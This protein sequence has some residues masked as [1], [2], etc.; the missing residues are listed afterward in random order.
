MNLRPALRVFFRDLSATGAVSDGLRCRGQDREQDLSQ[1]LEAVLNGR[2]PTS[3]WN[4]QSRHSQRRRHRLGLLT[5][6]YQFRLVYAGLDFESWCEWETDRWFDDGEGTEELG[7]LRQL[8]SPEALKPVR[9]GVSGLLDAV[10]ESR[11]RQADLSSVL[12]ENVRQAVEYLLEDVSAANRTDSNLFNSLVHH[13][14][15]PTLTDAQAQEALLQATVRVVMRLVVCLFAESRQLLPVND[16]IYAQAYGVRS[17]YESLEEAVRME[18]GVHTLFNHHIAWARLMA[19][20]R[21]IDEGSANGAFPLRADGGILFRR[22]KPDDPDPV[23]RALHLLEHAVPVGDA[24]MHAVLRKLMRGPLP[25][26]RG[27]QKTFV[28]GPVDYTDLRTEFIGLI[29][30][31]L[32]DYRVKRTD[33]EI[34]PQVFLHLGREPVLPLNRLEEMLANDRNGLKNLLTMLRKEA[35]TAK[36]AS[37]EEAEEEATDEPGDAP[38]DSPEDGDAEVEV[39][40]TAEEF[41]RGGEYLDAVASANRWA[42]AAVVLARL[43]SRQKARES[44]GEYRTRIEAEAKR[45]IKRVVATG[46][47][48]LVRAGNTRKG[49]ETFFTRPQLSVPTVHRTL[50]PLCYDRAGDGTLT[51]KPPEVI[52]GLKV[53]D[54]ACGSGSFL[55]GALHYLTDALYK[56][57]CYHKHLDDPAS[58]K[59]ITLP[60][61]RPR[62]GVETDN[63]V[64]FP[65]DDPQVGHTFEDRIKALLRR[66][67]VERCLYGVDL[68]PLAVEFARVS[69]WVETLDAELPFS[70]LDHKI[71]VGNSLVGCWLDRVKDYPLRE[72]EGGD[73]KHGPRTQVI[74]SFLKGDKVGNRWAGDGR[75]KQEM[76]EFIRLVADRAA[77][78]QVMLP[79]LDLDIERVVEDAR[80][81]FE[82]LHEQRI[83]DQEGQEGQ[84][85]R[86]R[87]IERSEPVRR[88]RRAM[89]EWCAVWFWPTDPE[90]MAHVPTPLTFHRESE[91]RSSLVARAR[92]RHAVLPLGVGVPRRVHAQAKRLRRHDRQP[93]VGRDRAQLA[94][95][96]YRL[97]PAVSD[98]RQAGRPAKAVGAVRFDANRC[99]GMGRLSRSLQGPR[100]LG[101]VC[102][103][104]LRPPAGPR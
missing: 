39:E 2:K 13:A 26:L 52:L 91:G 31:G 102:G 6:G 56:S 103:G 70:F 33:A 11:K 86:Y 28:E 18:G 1:C 19:L 96:L 84:E 66:H 17:L 95:V 87:A 47:F 63:L 36:V 54:P 104:P 44:D 88:L 61:G 35:V 15:E 21:L 38:E 7:G 10:E 97:R 40:A 46:E 12:R 5:N 20:F 55:V 90:S 9:E 8:L 98:I 48:Y 23:S 51:P 92:R 22:G 80:T 69:L 83:D 79:E 4:I 45:L 42:A 60:L 71:K 75:I 89:D 16:P 99:R 64:P 43:V 32:L 65:P 29:Y 73:G 72:R 101:Q 67:V 81:A 3:P 24:T 100:Q 58:V 77:G 85:D 37:E 53:C 74:E 14:G 50:E 62:T 57:L 82:A 94:G 49:T 25:V 78:Q 59:R 30:E 27:R 68:N 34:G 93:A 41:V 76:R